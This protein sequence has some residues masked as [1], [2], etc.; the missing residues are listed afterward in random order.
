MGQ[1]LAYELVDGGAPNSYLIRLTDA[2]QI[3]ALAVSEG[4]GKSFKLEPI[5]LI[6][7]EGNGELVLARGFEDATAQ[8]RIAMRVFGDLYCDAMDRILAREQ[9]GQAEDKS[10]LALSFFW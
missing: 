7:D 8:G 6:Y 4:I 9:S 3:A 1:K 2:K 5:P 10:R